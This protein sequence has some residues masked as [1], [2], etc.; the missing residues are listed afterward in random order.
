MMY[1]QKCYVPYVAIFLQYFKNENDI[2]GA[3]ML[4]Y[5]ESKFLSKLQVSD[6]RS[7]VFLRRLQHSGLLFPHSTPIPD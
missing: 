4:R 5:V 6:C 2:N 1:I 3:F 7:T